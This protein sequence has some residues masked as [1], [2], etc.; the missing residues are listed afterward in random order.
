VA[1]LPFASRETPDI[2]LSDA[3]WQRIET[4][5]GWTLSASLGD[6]ILRVTQEFLALESSE[7]TAT[8]LADVKIVLEAYD[9]A[10]GRFFN[11]IF[12][13]PSEQ[14]A[15]SIHAHS[16]IELHSKKLRK[17]K[18]NLFDAMLTLL[19]TFH[20]AS[21]T[22]MR[23]LRELQRSSSDSGDAWRLWIW[24]LTDLIG[25]A[26]LPA[27]VVGGKGE[28]HEPSAFVCFVWQLQR[29]LAE[30]V[31]HHTAS[32][33]ECAKAISDAQARAKRVKL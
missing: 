29:C 1:A 5:C 27:S 10:A 20:I 3:D 30:E 7:R 33:A 13:D 14:S 31:R 16:L 2:Q 19:R 22:A 32:E 26:R 15:A 28:S 9:K 25:A 8:S 12:A 11:A 21:N 24:R 6:N 18:E 23:E 4:A 17:G